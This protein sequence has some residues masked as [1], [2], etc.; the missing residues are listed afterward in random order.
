MGKK[1]NPKT[2]LVVPAVSDGDVAAARAALQ[3]AAEKRRQNSNMHYYLQSIG[4][5]DAYDCMSAAEKKEFFLKWFAKKVGEGN[6]VSSSSNRVA[7]VTEKGDD[8]VWMGKEKMI[9]ELGEK[10][11]LAKIES[12]VLEHRADPDT[13]MDDEW[14]REF[15]VYIGTGRVLERGESTHSLDTSADVQ[16]DVLKE[17][18]EDMAAAMSHIAGEKPVCTVA[19]KKEAEGGNGDAAVAK[20]DANLH[21][22]TFEA[23]QKNPRVTLRNCGDTIVTIK[24]MFEATQEMK[25]AEALHHD[26]SKLLPKFR[27]HYTNVEKLVTKGN[28]DEAVLLAIAKKLDAD[29]EQ[30]NLYADWYQKLT[31]QKP[32]KKSRKA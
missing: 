27:S 21:N 28:S 31:G 22:K 14:S 17:S 9:K 6:S 8:Y 29:Y 20:Y 12:G 1:A 4:K 16:G 23:L 25:Y 30:F 3:D 15:K 18:M 7:I 26:I 13:K 11:A 24:T 2:A 5:K 32:A 19:V 10:K